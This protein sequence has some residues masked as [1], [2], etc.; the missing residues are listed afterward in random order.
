MKIWLQSASAIGRDPLWES[1]EKALIE[2][3]QRVPRPG[4]T[5]TVHGVDKMSTGID[6]SRYIEFL[7]SPKIIDNAIQA[8]REGYDAFALTCML[9]PG[10]FEL[11]EAVD[12]PVVFA[13]ET[14]CHLA[15]MLGPKFALLAYNEII[16]R[17]LSEY[18]KHYGLGDR[19]VP[20]TS[21][22]V[23]LEALQDGF[24]DPEPLLKEARKLAKKADENGTDMLISLCGC[25]NMIFVSHGIR[26]IEG[27]PFI[28]SVGTAIKA[29]EMLV[30][31]KKMGIDRPR[32]GL[33]APLSKEQLQD[34]RK[35]YEAE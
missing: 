29:A 16:L 11:R 9:D 17:R 1:Y 18:V 7:N 20:T 4:T 8:E 33:Y 28:D 31:L 5:V 21:F 25:M 27:I 22:T 19:L 15:C 35:L 26:E 23:S 10:F 12:I 24:K 3:A 32:R 13:F 30:D 6:R 14:S 2:H 34:I